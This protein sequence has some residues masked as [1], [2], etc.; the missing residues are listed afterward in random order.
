[1]SHPRGVLR[2][3]LRTALAAS[4][5]LDGVEILQSWAQNVDADLLPVAG[6]F[7]PRE[8]SDPVDTTRVARTTDVVVMLRRSGGDTLED[9]LDDDSAAIEAAVMPVLRDFGAG[10]Y[11]L[12]STDISIDGQGKKRIGQIDMIFRAAR[13]TPEGQ[14]T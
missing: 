5:A 9:A 11:Q 6:V 14:S 12:A 4:A 2:A 1:M 7:T 13:Y 8:V 3:S 10:V